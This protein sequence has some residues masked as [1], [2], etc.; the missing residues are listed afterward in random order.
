M[1]YVSLVA[2]SGACRG[3]AQSL[4]RRIGIAQTTAASC[5][6]VSMSIIHIYVIRGFSNCRID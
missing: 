5:D 6:A 3:S 4:L 2:Q 1:E